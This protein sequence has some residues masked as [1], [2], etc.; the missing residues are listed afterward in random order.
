MKNV[1]FFFFLLLLSLTF[2]M[3]GYG[4]VSYYQIKKSNYLSLYDS[5]FKQLKVKLPTNV[6]FQKV[7]QATASGKSDYGII[8]IPGSKSS[9]SR[10]GLYNGDDIAALNY[11]GRSF[12]VKETELD[13]ASVEVEL[14]SKWVLGGFI[15]PF[16]YRPGKSNDIPSDIVSNVSGLFNIGYKICPYRTLKTVPDGIYVGAVLGPFA[17]ESADRA[18]NSTQSNIPG[19]SYGGSLTFIIYNRFTG[20]VCAGFDQVNTTVDW[21]YNGRPWVGFGFGV[22]FSTDKKD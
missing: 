18:S 14:A 16:K 20:I 10:A 22:S 13:A 7:G 1:S 11:F 19:L 3:V 2:S 4:Q 12:Y 15:L 6:F 8:Y 17:I 9:R 21:A 5:T